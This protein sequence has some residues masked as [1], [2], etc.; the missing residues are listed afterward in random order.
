MS[1]KKCPVCGYVTVEGDL[2]CPECGNK[3]PEIQ[4]EEPVVEEP[5]VED[6]AVEEP[7]VESADVAESTDVDVPVYESPTEPAVEAP[8]YEAPE[9]AVEAPVYETPEPAVEAP[10]Y[11]T[12]AAPQQVYEPVAATPA[13]AVKKP[14]KKSAGAV[15]A[16]IFISLFFIIFTLYLGVVS[17]VKY[18]VTDNAVDRTLKELRLSEITLDFPNSGET[19]LSEYVT[20]ILSLY[21]IADVDEDDV[22]DALNCKEV[23]KLLKSAITNFA[24]DFINDDDAVLNSQLMH[25][26][27]Y[28]VCNKLNITYDEYDN[29][30]PDK[31]AKLIENDL[32]W[33]DVLEEVTS[34]N[35]TD[36]FATAR[37]A[38]I[39][40]S[41][42][43]FIIIGALTL[44]MLIVLI[45]LNRSALSEG[46][47]LL[48]ES[49]IYIFISVVSFIG[50]ETFTTEKL[51][52]EIGN[53][54]LA[55]IRP[56]TIILGLGML[57]VS[58]F[59]IVISAKVRKKRRARAKAYAQQNM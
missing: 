46:I 38:Q 34:E 20:H 2:F 14:F 6:V 29:Y 17:I 1:D 28:I 45:I 13:K 36:D 31:A 42:V 41:K 59:M 27:V 10:V 21:E 9:P 35:L 50:I 3:F 23:R 24:E 16:S 55:G 56:A 51:V 25:N 40:L 33:T 7:F 44:I 32:D 57:A 30:V 52:K 15:V 4:F 19:S 18:A 5:V 43:T 49:L 48:F 8:V 37:A 22:T 53:P 54:V 47:I 11:G 26:V 12:P 58:I 39:A